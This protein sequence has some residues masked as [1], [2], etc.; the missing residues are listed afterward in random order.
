MFG[1]DYEANAALDARFSGGPTRYLLLS[2]TEPLFASGGYTNVTEPTASD[3]ARVAVAPGDWPAASSRSVATTVPL[4]DPVEDWG[5][6]PYWGLAS[7]SS[8]GT[9]AWV[10]RF[11]DPLV[12]DAGASGVSVTLRIESPAAL[13]DLD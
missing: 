9:V 11:E 8:G 2:S 13:S 1:I 6:L 4:P 10:G 3:Y 5:D 7:A 12:L